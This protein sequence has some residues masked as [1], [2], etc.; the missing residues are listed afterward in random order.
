MLK[1]KTT[2]KVIFSSRPL[3]AISD[4][5]FVDEP[6]SEIVLAGPDMFSNFFAT[7][8]LKNEY[9]ITS[10]HLLFNRLQI[11]FSPVRCCC[12][13]YLAVAIL[14]ALKKYLLYQLFIYLTYKA[15]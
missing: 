14:Q 8:A 1:P 2:A 5:H 6:R 3:C 9:G 4:D 7:S 12:D 10:L 15:G 13:A 11:N